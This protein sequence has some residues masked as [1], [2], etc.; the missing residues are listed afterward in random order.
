[1]PTL[2]VAY[3]NGKLACDARRCFFMLVFLFKLLRI[4]AML[5]CPNFG[6]AVTFAPVARM[7]IFNDRQFSND[8]NLLR[9]VVYP[10]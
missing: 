6:T 8:L 4:C 9:F 7:I 10:S 1:M 3:I 5:V 2:S